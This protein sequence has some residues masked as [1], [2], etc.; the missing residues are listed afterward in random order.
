VF[1]NAGIAFKKVRKLLSRFPMAAP[2]P[3]RVRV[4][5]KSSGTRERAALG[6]RPGPTVG[7]VT[8]RVPAACISRSSV[9]HKVRRVGSEASFWVQEAPCSRRQL[10]AIVRNFMELGDEAQAFGGADHVG[11]GL[12]ELKRCALHQRGGLTKLSRAR[13]ARDPRG[14]RLERMGENQQS[15]GIASEV[16]KNCSHEKSRIGIF[17]HVFVRLMAASV[18]VR[19][20]RHGH[21]RVAAQVQL[22][23]MGKSR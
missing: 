2:R 20:G 18:V 22:P 12:S 1:L 21:V 13:A 17:V 14:L 23:A 6:G 3:L 4:V 11:G 16:V 5:R 19:C 15:F 8:A 7:G 10:A 9:L